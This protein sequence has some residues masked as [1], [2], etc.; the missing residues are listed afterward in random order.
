MR[1]QQQV[2]AR[3]KAPLLTLMAGGSPEVVH[4]LLAHVEALVERA[5]AEQSA[6]QSA[7]RS[8]GAGTVFSD[9]VR[10]F[11]TRYDE[12]TY[13]KYSKVRLLGLLAGSAT[14]AEVISELSEYVTDV[15][16]ELA[17]R[18][19]RVCIYPY[20]YHMLLDTVRSTFVKH[21]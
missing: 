16:A 19:I 8:V 2:Y 21:S 12:P 5:A 11:F 20:V 10:L 3:M 1:T 9:D 7:E 17:R 15:D 6:E 14:A 4:C 13:V 18:A